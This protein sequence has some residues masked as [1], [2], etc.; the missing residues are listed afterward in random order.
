MAR[1]LESEAEG[2]SR[3]PG[4]SDLLEEAT[5]LRRDNAS[6]LELNAALR[7]SNTALK[8][9]NASLE[10][11]NA[12]LRL[13]A[14]LQ[15]EL[16]Q[17][18]PGFTTWRS[19]IGVQTGE[20]PM[21]LNHVSKLPQELLLR[22]FLETIPPDEHY[23]LS[24]Q[25]GARN[26][27]LVSVGTRRALT[28]VCKAW[29]GP[30][31]EALYVDVAIR[32]M[33]Q[34]CALARTLRFTGRDKGSDRSKFIKRLRIIGCVVL[35]RAADVV[36]EDLSFILQSC[37]NIMDF[38]WHPTPS[39]YISALWERPD[40]TT[41]LWHNPAWFWSL[42]E[43]T[44]GAALAGC[45]AAGLRRL[46]FRENLWDDHK[47]IHHLL[48]IQTRLTTLVLGPMFKGCRSLSSNSD[49]PPVSLP[50]LEYLEICNEDRLS[51]TEYNFASWDMPHL[52]R[53]TVLS[54]GEL[55]DRLLVQF[56]G[57]LEYLHVMPQSQR[58][59][60]VPW[61]ETLTELSTLCPV[62]KHLVLVESS[63][64]SLQCNI[65]SE[66][67]LHL[68]IWG[69]LQ[70]R[71]VVE[72]NVRD[73]PRLWTAQPA[74]PPHAAGRLAS[75]CEG[76]GPLFCHPE[77]VS[78]DEICIKTVV[79]IRLLQTSWG[80][81]P[82]HIGRRRL[83]FLGVPC[84]EDSD[85]DEGSS[86]DP[87][88]AALEEDATSWISDSSA[89][90]DSGADYSADEDGEQEADD[91]EPPPQQYDRDAVLEMYALGQE[92]DFRFNDD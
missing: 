9:S 3:Q 15:Q 59:K 10:Q 48:Q 35:D 86:Y 1:P 79:G 19:D 63:T 67:L 27:W 47:Y 53:L 14:S 91:V 43:G 16:S 6:L 66:T 80:L 22:V 31:S 34:I 5:R 65:E 42:N 49:A 68:D 32:R 76:T 71:R 60:E 58:W 13:A 75:Q 24:V 37:S 30:A 44:P 85:S 83:R 73:G 72:L 4:V 45:C 55:L 17:Y 51:Y 70:K 11:A 21:D 7:E 12:V 28:L 87:A 25:A 90:T 88:E 38:E 20:D 81:L 36:E 46:A 56:G 78:G 89:S 52:T 54:S 74:H 26:P 8:Q 62:L 41:S 18:R 39:D 23:V 92:Q 69:V 64:L 57:R 40:G 2:T 50:N 82:D 29:H 61:R 77:D 33:G 84:D